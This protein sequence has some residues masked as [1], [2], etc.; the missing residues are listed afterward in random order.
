MWERECGSVR[1]RGRERAWERARGL[2]RGM[3]ESG[4]TREGAGDIE[5][6]ENERMSE[7][8]RESVLERVRYVNLL[9]CIF[10]NIN[11]KK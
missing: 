1:E 11:E 5:S 6:G 2:E 10:M 3:G 8:K 4:R 9:I 7:R